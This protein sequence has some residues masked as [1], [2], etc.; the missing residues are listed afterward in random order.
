MPLDLVGITNPAERID[1]GAVSSAFAELS[2]LAPR[3][4][5]AQS[6]GTLHAAL[7][8]GEAQRSGRM[9]LG[10]DGLFSATIT[11]G[12]SS[13]AGRLSVLTLQTGPNEFLIAGSGEASV[14]FTSDRPGSPIVGIES[15]DE[16]FLHAGAPDSP[17][18]RLNGDETS[19]GQALRLFASDA[20]QGRIYRVRLYRYR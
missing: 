15:I 18:R 14:T 2:M 8:E 4:L 1:S 19:Q 10:K 7:L 13:S 11:R 12:G 16:I 20:G 17:G 5:Q 9:L 6:A 3:I